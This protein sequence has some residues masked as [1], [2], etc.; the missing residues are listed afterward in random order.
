MKKLRMA[1]LFVLYATVLIWLCDAAV[2]PLPDWAL[3]LNGISMM[4][5]MAALAFATVRIALVEGG[6]GKNS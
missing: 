6:T 5:G 4:A 2:L 3:R 1:A